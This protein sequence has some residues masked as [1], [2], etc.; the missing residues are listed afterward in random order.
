MFNLDDNFL[1]ELG[2]G[3]LPED[4]KQPFLQLVYDRLEMR[5]GTQLSEG[6]SDEQLEEFEKIIDR[7][8]ATIN[9]WLTSHAPNFTGDEAFQRLKQAMGREVS[10]PDLQAEYA[11][12]KWLELNRP[13]YR[14]VVARVLEE[15]K[16]EIKGNRDAIIG[17][18]TA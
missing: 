7:D 6:M 1:E 10:D 2:L 13:D 16:E 5:V 18:A 9:Q 11:A 3:G 12:T 8:T 4:Q 14:Q 17:G 15:I